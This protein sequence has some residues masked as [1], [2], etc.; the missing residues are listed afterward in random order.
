MAFIKHEQIANVVMISADYHFAREWS[1]KRTGVH[2]FTAGPLAS[3]R[4][5]D[6][7]PSA[8]ERHSKGSHFVFGDDFNFGLL[9]YD[10]ARKTLTVSYRDSAGKT[11]FEQAVG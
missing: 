11:L 6:K 7:S 4:T 8:R 1:G 2:E 9:N 3:F 5:F 10:G